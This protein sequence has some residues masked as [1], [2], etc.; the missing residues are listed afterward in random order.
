M[1]EIEFIYNQ[2]TT[3]IQAKSDEP[4]K[5]IINKFLQKSLLEEKNVFFIANGKPISSEKTVLSHMNQM[6]KENNKLK[7]L[8]QLTEEENAKEQTFVKSKDIICPECHQ[9]CIIKSNNY[10]LSLLG[11][12][13][14]H[15][16]NLKIK[17]FL[18]TQNINIS[19]IICE[20][21]KIKDKS[22]SPNNEFYKC[23]TCNKNLCL[24]CKSV[25][26][27]EHNIINYDH[28]NYICEKHYEQYIGYCINCNKNICFSCE[29]EHTGHKIKSLNELKPNIDDIKNK[30]SEMKK[31]IDIFTNGL[32]QII[33]QLN[34]L[35]DNI[36]IYY[37][38][39]N[40]ILNNYEKKKRN[41]QMLQNIN[42]IN[43]SNNKI[44]NNLKNINEMNNIKEKLNNIMDL[45]NN[46][47][48][49]NNDVEDEIIDS[50]KEDKLINNVNNNISYNIN[51]NDNIS[52]PTIKLNQ[53]TIIYSIP[54]FTFQNKIRI[55]GASFVKNNKDNCHLLIDDQVNE[56]HEHLKLNKNQINKEKLEIKL[57]ETKIITN[58]YN[59]FNNCSEL[60]SLPDI[61]EWDTINVT[62]ISNMFYKCSSLLSLSDISKW[63]TENV[64]KMSF[65]FDNCSSLKS[66]PD[67][68]KWNTKNVTD[69][70][71]MFYHC[72]SFISL[73]DISKWD[74]SKVI[75]MANMF[76]NCT[77]L[78][79]LPDISVWNTKNLA[80]TN[81]MF[82]NCKALTSFPDIS[83]WN[84]SK[85]TQK[86]SMFA[87]VDKYIIPQMFK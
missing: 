44:F 86:D 32:K 57:I 16:T 54:K 46:I 52:S 24:L 50:D 85:L 8:V 61:S 30:I 21:C 33:S 70:S 26:Q 18:G 47:N 73:P 1:T 66:L 74:T 2:Q 56:L 14:N 77:S 82:Y 3:I 19:N 7:I 15:K 13:Q 60:I 12:I 23:L 22:N 9:P 35:I 79:S 76:Y 34:E 68:S 83:K 64:T 29:D 6:N 10:K 63:N 41:Y 4:L 43:N 11:C 40:N 48:S 17:D 42:Q 37:E 69:M 59:M 80:F 72:N 67:I 25:H 53:M 39:N 84:T 55:F 36:N 65:M 49:D 27:S 58:F 87:G 28:I 45:Y 5:D 31:E 38:I 62:N 75:N 78:T 81:S 20:K 51:N 71:G